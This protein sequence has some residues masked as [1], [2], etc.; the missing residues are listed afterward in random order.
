MEFLYNIIVIVYFLYAVATLLVGVWL[1]RGIYQPDLMS[2]EQHASARKAY[3]MMLILQWIISIALALLTETADKTLFFTFALLLVPIF[4]S[5][6]FNILARRERVG[7][8]GSILL[9]FLSIASLFA[10]NIYSLYILY[11]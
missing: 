4:F 10:V 6:W 1:L 7:Y 2:P 3:L 11:V 8:G 9:I 5:M